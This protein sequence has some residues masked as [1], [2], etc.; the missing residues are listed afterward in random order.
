MRDN[1]H[2]RRIRIRSAHRGLL[3][4]RRRERTDSWRGRAPETARDLETAWDLTVG[5]PI[6]HDGETSIIHRAMR[7]DGSHAILKLSAPGLPVAREAEALRIIDGQCAVK[8]LA[9]DEDRGA[10][11]LER[12]DSTASLERLP[13]R[14][15]AIDLGL[16]LLT[17]WWRPVSRSTCLP[18]APQV[19][20]DDRTALAARRPWLIRR[21]PA[22][23][24]DRAL[25][26]LAEPVAEAFL[27]HSDLHLGNVL[28]GHRGW[29]AIDPQ[30]LIGPRA[31]DLEA[32]LR[33]SNPD[34]PA[35][36][37]ARFERLVERAGLDREP[38]ARIVLARGL[39]VGS[40]SI[41]NFSDDW[42]WR[43]IETVLLSVS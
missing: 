29:M 41:E 18:H 1:H 15:A 2:S 20:E 13:D 43:H 4:G 24:V 7:A 33:D 6:E 14:D 39:G 31:H 10:L 8:L 22:K 5:P 11:L 9:S 36:A 35:I 42:G 28:M 19:Y 12:V 26:V 38:A 30:P 32:L 3:R 25:E 34:S 27:L 17:R 21:V 23:V 37:R 40:W 16:E